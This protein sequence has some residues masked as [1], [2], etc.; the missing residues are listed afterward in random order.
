MGRV[1]SSRRD[2]A[3][4]RAAQVV[5]S[6]RALV[7]RRDTTLSGAAGACGRPCQRRPLR[8]V[9]ED[10]ILVLGDGAVYSGKT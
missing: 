6:T 10:M 1:Q 8:I 5:A 3:H 7:A 9:Q 4:G 2:A